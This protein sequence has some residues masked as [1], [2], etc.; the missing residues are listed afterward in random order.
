MHAFG[1][2]T[3]V[4]L[5]GDIL[6]IHVHTD[7]PDAVFSYASRWGRVDS[8]KAEDMRVQHRRLGHTSAAGGGHR[9]R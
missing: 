8:T 2:S 3:V 7:T 1:G 9:N 5:M 6:K 4:A